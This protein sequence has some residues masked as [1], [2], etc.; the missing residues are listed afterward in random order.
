MPSTKNRIV[1][2]MV[3]VLLSGCGSVSQQSPEVF[4]AGEGAYGA[5]ASGAEVGALPAGDM[6][7]LDIET[8]GDQ[9]DTLDE[10]QLEEVY[11]A[12]PNT[13]YFELNSSNLSPEGMDTLSRYIQVLNRSTRDIKV[14]GHTD[15]QGTAS[16]NV[17]LSHNRAL[18][19]RNY[20]V[21]EGIAD[22]RITITGYGEEQL[23]S[24]GNSE[25]DHQQNR[26]AE[27]VK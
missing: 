11:Q 25:L 17:S 7:G 18:T 5:E 8:F 21:S 12:L 10:S 26:R 9:L 2:A 23:V 13:V 16:Y 22:S 20:L 27:V 3:T 15:S 19:V 14:N 6:V 4:E 1:M 24:F